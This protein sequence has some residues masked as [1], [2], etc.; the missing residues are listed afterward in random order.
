MQYNIPWWWRQTRSL[1]HWTSILV[2]ME[3][4]HV[5]ETLD[6]CSCD[7]GDRPCLWNIGLLFLWWW[8][9][10][11][12]LKHWTSVL[13]MM[14]TDQVSETLDFYSCDDG[15]RP[16]LWNTGLL[17]LWWW[18]QTM[19]LKHWTSILNWCHW[20]PD[21]DVTFTH[22]KHKYNHDRRGTDMSQGISV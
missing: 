3:T 9:Q 7:D 19:S 17:F 15:D 5:S 8:R 18:R 2:V 22:L 12:S 13:V 21:K 20:T 11:R 14:E 16:C 10:T 6:F 4:D 1:K